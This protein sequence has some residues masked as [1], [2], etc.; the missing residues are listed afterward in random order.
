MKIVIE[1]ESAEV[2]PS[3]NVKIKFLPCSATI[4]GSKLIPA[5]YYFGEL[6]QP[7]YPVGLD[8]GD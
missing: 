7:I 8:C 1:V 2:L 6:K 3:G 5:E 4:D